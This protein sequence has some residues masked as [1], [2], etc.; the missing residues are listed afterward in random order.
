MTSLV[1][2][3]AIDTPSDSIATSRYAADKTTTHGAGGSGPKAGR[4]RILNCESVDG[5]YFFVKKDE[6]PTE[7]AS[8]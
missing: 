5:L 8:F 4:R 3:A 6:I 2:L 7:V 1:Q